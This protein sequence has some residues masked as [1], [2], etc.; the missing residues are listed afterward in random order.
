MSE[1][2][3]EKISGSNRMEEII[4]LIEQLENDLDDVRNIVQ[5]LEMSLENNQDDAHIIKSVNIIDKML[6]AVM[7]KRIVELKEAV[8]KE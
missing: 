2:S 7:E 1:S 8:W 5:L 3:K 4:L 6:S